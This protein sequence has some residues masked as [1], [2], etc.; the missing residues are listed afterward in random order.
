MLFGECKSSK[1]RYFK[2]AYNILEDD[3]YCNC[4]AKKPCKHIL[5]LL[6]LHVDFPELL[7]QTDDYPDWV[8]EWL[9]KEKKELTEAEKEAIET[10]KIANRLANLDKRILGMREGAKELQLWLEDLVRQGLA[11]AQTQPVEFWEDF[12]AQMVDRKLSRAAKIIRTFPSLMSQ[13]D[14]FEKVASKTASLFLIA[15]GLQKI[16]QLD[17]D[18]QSQVLQEAGLNIKKDEVLKSESLIDHWLVLGKLESEEDNLQARRTWLIGQGTGKIAMLLDFVWGRQSFEQNW[19]PGSAFAGEMTF[20]PGSFQL[21]SI[22]KSFEPS[23]DAFSLPPGIKDFT[24]L[25]NDYVQ[26]IGQNP[27]LEEIFVLLQDIVP[28]VKSDRFFIADQSEK[29]VS[30]ESGKTLTNWKILAISSGH[31]ITIFGTWNNQ[32]FHP[33]SVI[34]QN[35]IIPLQYE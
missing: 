8:L 26:A 32:I 20:Y 11:E 28:W 13:T 18:L 29:S 23:T 7:G 6:Y 3:Y 2:T 1:A 22:F 16:D 10:E 9:Q 30:L 34:H 4:S 14:G 35:R 15:K 21:R 31:P 19:I 12:A 17:A 27:W 25:R 24:K 33:I 5:G